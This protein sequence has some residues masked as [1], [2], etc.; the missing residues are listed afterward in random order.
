MHAAA[1]VVLINRQNCVHICT[2][3]LNWMKRKQKWIFIKWNETEWNELNQGESEQIKWEKHLPNKVHSQSAK[4]KSSDEYEMCINLNWAEHI[5]TN[6]E[7]NAQHRLWIEST[8]QRVS[9]CNNRHNKW[10]IPTLMQ[11]HCLY[12][13]ATIAALT[14]DYK[15]S[16]LQHR[17]NL[18]NMAVQE[19]I[20]QIES[21]S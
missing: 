15:N 12:R 4:C 6:Q 17:R 7:I 8:W 9:C 13:G 5:T 10:E 14:Q 18:P 1:L 21:M 11:F 16:A 3:L 2:I 19:P 20:S